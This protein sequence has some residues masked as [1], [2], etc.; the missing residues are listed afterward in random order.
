MRQHLIRRKNSKA[1]AAGVPLFLFL[2]ASELGGL[3]VVTSNLSNYPWLQV[4]ARATYSTLNGTNVF[5]AP[6]FVLANGTVLFAL[7][8]ESW[9][10]ANLTWSVTNRTP[11]TATL[12]VTYSIAGADN[13]PPPR[14]AKLLY[15]TELVRFS[16]QKS[17][18]IV[19][20]LEN[21]TASVDGSPEG[22][23]NFW[24]AP[25]PATGVSLTLGTVLVGSQTYQVSGAVVPLRGPIA[26][27]VFPIVRGEE[28]SVNLMGYDLTQEQFVQPLISRTAWLNTTGGGCDYN[29]TNHC[30]IPITHTALPPYAD[31]DYF[32]GL[33][34]DFSVP[35]Y[36]VARTVCQFANNTLYD[37][38]YVPFGTSLGEY[39][40]SGGATL[41]LISTNVQIGPPGTSANP[42]SAYWFALSVSAA[43]VVVGSV[44]YLW[45]RHRRQQD[46]QFRGSDNQASTPVSAA[47]DLGTVKISGLT[48]PI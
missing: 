9:A 17:I 43:V 7:S 40:R 29:G 5:N 6:S 45:R 34:L 26:R 18:I 35:E 4:G 27:P 31:Y 32:S 21:N 20:N 13:P 38:G 41:W 15:G 8:S 33:A 44:T 10:E 30:V 2:F 37:C 12:N 22:I 47:T 28:Y 42:Y 3:G 39:F 46:G 1:L 11:D 36:Q 24:S 25:L 14:D 23:I 48:S 16:Y 19:V